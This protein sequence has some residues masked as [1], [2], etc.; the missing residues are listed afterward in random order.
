M[1]AVDCLQPTNHRQL[2]LL[3]RDYWA[4]LLSPTGWQAK[5]GAVW[6]NASR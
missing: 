1:E 3:S 5:P 2:P 4:T 6:Y